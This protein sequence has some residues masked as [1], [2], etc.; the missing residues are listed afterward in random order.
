MRVNSINFNTSFK[1]I[2]KFGYSDSVTEEMR[3]K[4][5]QRI[6]DRELYN[7]DFFLK[8]GR[9]SEF[10][11]K[12]M[13]DELYKKPVENVFDEDSL[14]A[15]CPNLIHVDDNKN[16][17]RGASL[18]EKGEET[19]DILKSA[20]I[21]TIIDLVGYSEYEE[22]CDEKKLNYVSFPIDNSRFISHPVFNTEA[23]YLREELYWYSLERQEE[24]RPKI[25]ENYNFMCRNFIDNFVNVVQALQ[26]G[27]C[28][29]SCQYGSEVTSK[30]LKLNY[31]FNPQE[32]VFNI[33]IDE[34]MHKRCTRLYNKLTSED[35]AK[36]GWNKE[37]DENF[38]ARLD[39]MKV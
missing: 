5:H 19:F 2:N 4:L 36:M 28:Y 22:K 32:E 6:E 37:F 14:Y 35:K 3:A 12:K 29:I 24:Y 10:E 11:E 25:K 27:N 23:N 8:E 39:E 38:I 33:G 13:I 18:V 17:W 26:K 21:D 30:M 7:V 16:I 1:S 9:K 20:K 15:V 34:G 31:I